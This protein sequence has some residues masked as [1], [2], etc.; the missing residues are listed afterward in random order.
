MS[1]IWGGGAIPSGDGNA[2]N[3]MDPLKAFR[4]K[5]HRKCHD[6]NTP[7]CPDSDQREPCIDGNLYGSTWFVIDR[8]STAGVVTLDLP[9]LLYPSRNFE[10]MDA[11]PLPT[12]FVL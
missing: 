11:S 12:V 4:I 1:T 10:V 6:T 5:F 9:R 3:S 8:D 7:V 2:V